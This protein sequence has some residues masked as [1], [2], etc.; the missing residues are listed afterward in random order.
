[1]KRLIFAALVAL[2]ILPSVSTAATFPILKSSST[3]ATGYFRELPANPGSFAPGYEIVL[4]ALVQSDSVVVYL[5][6]QGFHSMWSNSAATTA[7]TGAIFVSMDL[8]G[9]ADSCTVTALTG[10][11]IGGVFTTVFGTLQ[12][13]TRTNA[14]PSYANYVATAAAWLPGQILRLNLKSKGVTAIE[15]GRKVI[16]RFPRQTPWHAPFK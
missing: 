11:R 3:A 2:A 15:A 1:M 6:F 5:P 8:S 9:A 14:V 12:A 13:M 7:P 16:V 10:Q 4:P